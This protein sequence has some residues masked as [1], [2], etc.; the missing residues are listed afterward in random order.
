M[1]DN[2]EYFNLLNI[3]INSLNYDEVETLLN[4]KEELS[5]LSEYSCN[6]IIGNVLDIEDKFKM[7]KLLLSNGLKINNN[8]ED[9]IAYNGEHKTLLQDYVENYIINV[10]DLE[11]LY[12]LLSYGAK[13]DR[14]TIYDHEE[15]DLYIVILIFDLLIKYDIYSIEKFVDLLT[16][17]DIDLNFV[18]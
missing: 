1:G 13:S 15:I 9:I 5:S 16:N 14:I 11:G 4:R 17:D 2:I 10:E 8:R 3:A 12:L 18:G 6:I 7:M